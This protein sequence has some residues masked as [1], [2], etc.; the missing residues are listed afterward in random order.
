MKINV[1]GAGIIGTSLAQA[2]NA[3]GADVTLVDPNPPG[4]LASAASFGWI[5]ASYGNP[6]PYFDL[7]VASM[8]EWQRLKNSDPD[9]P[10]EKNGTIILHYDTDHETHFDAQTA[11]GYNLEWMEQSSIAAA[12]PNL[13]HVPKIG[14]KAPDEGQL[15]VEAAARHFAQRLEDEGGTVRLTSVEKIELHQAD[16]TVLAAGAAS[17]SL[18]ADIDVNIPMTAPPGL[19]AY[20]KPLS[21]K[22]LNHT[23]LADG[24]HMQQRRDGRLVAGADFGGGQINDDPI[25]GAAEIFGRLEKA[26]PG[27]DLEPDGHTLGR[28]PTPIDGLP[29][30]GRSLQYDNLYITVMHS[31]A[32]LAP[33]VAKLA[34]EDILNGQRDPLLDR[35]GMDRF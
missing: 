21:A 1:I 2:L 35:F 25:K 26:L 8:Q 12:E 7:R 3:K 14:L 28:R 19:L 33:I 11:W 27:F 4:G 22:T 9:L 34:A 29:I 24:L 31:G 5:N 15:D 23:I 17:A 13:A 32:T 16:M 18:A 30:I 10:F 20:T 6:R